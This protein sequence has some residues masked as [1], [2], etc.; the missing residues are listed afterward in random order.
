MQPAAR[1]GL[2]A[3]QVEWLIRDA[4]SLTIGRGLELLDNAL[5][6]IED[7]SIDLVD[8][9]VTR[10]SYADLHGRASIAIARELPWGS[11]IVR[12][13][14]TLAGRGAYVAPSGA[15]SDLDARARF[16]LGAYYTAAPSRTLGASP[17]TFSVDCF[18]LLHGLTSPTG[19][20][21]VAPAGATYLS[22][23]QR[24]LTDQGYTR[25]VID[26]AKADVVLPSARVWP[27]EEQTTWL[28][29]VNT[30]LDAIGYQGIWSDWDGQL[31][32][33]AYQ[34]PSERAAEW[35]YTVDGAASQLAPERTV[36]RDL[37]STPNRWVAVRSNLTDQ[38]APV[39]GAGVYT[40]TQWTGGPTSVEARGGRVITRMLSLEAADQDSLI[41][42]AQRSI[43][44]DQRIATK[45]SCSTSPN[46]LHW[47]FDRLAL[48]DP[49][50]GPVAQMQGTAWSLPLGGGD[51]THSWSAL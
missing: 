4:P 43:D 33:Q 13:Y 40:Y 26:P 7:V 9:E 38:A 45:I 11:A 35:T 37:F 48:D 46:P 22:E 19:Q 16:N 3:H 47:H 32:C 23:V 1:D 24:V 51:Q 31:R 49:E 30:L 29:V 10:E 2:T 41:A 27:M 18:D 20:V 50:V 12:P 5:G 36:E 21:W 39:E 28:T 25:V 15:I 14:M 6:V 42:A 44:A 17:V 34:P 8:G